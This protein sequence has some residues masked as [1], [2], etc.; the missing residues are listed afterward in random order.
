MKRIPSENFSSSRFRRL[1]PKKSLI[2]T[3]F[4]YCLIANL[5]FTVGY[6]LLRFNQSE[7]LTQLKLINTADNPQLLLM[8]KMNATI[9]Q[10]SNISEVMSFEHFTFVHSAFRISHSEIRL[11]I[12]RSIN[13]SLP[14]V[15]EYG[16]KRSGFVE[17][18]CHRGEC[19]PDNFSPPCTINGY[20][21][22]INGLRITDGDEFIS[23]FSNDV[24]HPQKIRVID[25]RRKPSNSTTY[26]H[27]LGVCVQPI[28]LHT[29]YSAFIHF[30]EYW[31]SEGAT[32][33]ILY[34]ESYSPDVARILEFYKSTVNLLNS[35]QTKTPQIEID[36][37]DWSRLP[38]PPNM[39]NDSKSNP[40]YYWF[41]LEVFTA[42]FDCVNRARGKVKYVALTDVDE[43]LWI[44][45]NR[46]VIS[47]MDSLNSTDPDM[48]AAS[49]RSQRAKLK[50]NEWK[51]I[52][53]PN[54]PS[55]FDFHAFSSIRL[56]GKI[57][58]R[59]LYSKFIVR[60]ERMLHLHI[61]RPQ[62]T[63]LIP[64]KHL[65]YKHVNVNPKD[66]VVLH[67]R[68]LRDMYRWENDSSSDILAQKQV[69]WE[70][71]FS[72]RIQHYN[73]GDGTKWN[74]MPPQFS[75]DLEECRIIYESFS[76][77]SNKT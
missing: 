72:K 73:F 34:R 6:F 62:Q 22:Y 40:N 63:E 38:T 33:F 64:G 36:I 52:T 28:Y 20:I 5:I 47:F 75:K 69:L 14:I 26:Q 54:K 37:V 70:K 1:M 45:K 25:T 29:D 42:I 51:N 59:P 65:R 24:M 48:A 66:G 7:T 31:I 16:P 13:N 57:F 67:L 21:G 46:S 71:N 68:R 11:T 19:Y 15:Y 58:A 32:K 35:T 61:H 2:V 18:E 49:F 30:F 41:R 76:L 77:L 56:E 55:N 60:P 44:S 74:E 12:V 39:A 27:Q 50:E 17:L 43:M 9:V 8:N 23:L 4:N 53:K 10:N 3:L